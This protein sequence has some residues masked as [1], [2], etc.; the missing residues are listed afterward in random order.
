MEY[1]FTAENGGTR[2]DKYLG[3]SMEGFTRSRL[4][5]LIESGNVTVNGKSAAPK[6]IVR[7]GDDIFINVDEPQEI[8]VLPEDIP[9]DI[10]YEDGDI[11]VVN[12]PKGMVVHPAPG[13][14]SGTLVNALLYH[15]GDLSGI[16]GKLRPGIVHRIDKD[17][18]GLIVVAKNDEAHISLAKQIEEKT[19][20]RI[21]TALLFGR[22]GEGAGVID[23]PIE[24]HR[25]DR[26]RMAIARPGFGRRAVTHYEVKA[27][28][29]KYTLI[30]ARLETG[31]THQIRVHMAYK[32]HPVVGDE[33]YCKKKPPFVTNGQ[34]LHAGRLIL[35]HPRT[36]EVME[37]SAPLPEYFVEILN[38]LTEID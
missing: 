38:K 25:T 20:G 34:M 13:N 22:M 16:N 28:F 2:L 29:D 8:D 7:P 1:R 35:T 26:K 37:F 23:A 5:K 24:R 18:T 11:I 17:T 19:A 21:Y 30:E 9:L 31:R 6:Q 27:L 15:C 3:E 33:V 4:Q 10:V 12:K 14:R 32:G 36:G